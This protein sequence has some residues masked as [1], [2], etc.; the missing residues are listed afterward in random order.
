VNYIRVESGKDGKPSANA[1]R[2]FCLL[3]QGES[4]FGLYIS[5]TKS[6]DCEGF[7]FNQDHALLTEEEQKISKQYWDFCHKQRPRVRREIA[8]ANKAIHQKTGMRWFL[9]WIEE[10]DKLN[11]QFIMD[12]L[13]E[14]IAFRKKFELSWK[15]YLQFVD[16][17]ANF[18]KQYLDSHNQTRLLDVQQKEKT[19]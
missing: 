12:H 2:G 9:D 5:N 13:E 19:P 6:N 16:L 14:L 18:G 1:L 4:D 8:R 10:N 7:L 17:I 11:Q 3:G 15:N